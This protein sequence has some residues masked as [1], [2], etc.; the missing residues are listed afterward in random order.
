VR[1]M[2]KKPI[3]VKISDYRKILDMLDTTKEKIIKAKETLNKIEELKNKE[4][5]ELEHWKEK[6]EIIES[7]IK[8]IDINL[9]EPDN[10]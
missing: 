7:K 8:N 3:F 10:L 5:F 6:I 9:L 2:D 4:N 1:K